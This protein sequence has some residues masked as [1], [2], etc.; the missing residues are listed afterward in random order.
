[1]KVLHVIPS[2]SPARGGPSFSVRAVTAGL[3]SLGATVHV[4]TTDD[5]GASRLPVPLEVA[6][7]EQG[8]TYWRFPR[9]IRF[10]TVSWPLARWLRAHCRD[11]DV[12]HI[13]AVF[14]YAC[15][16]AAWTAREAGLPYIVTPRGILNR[17]GIHTRRP[18]LKRLSYHLI[19][20]RFL[21]HATF[22]QY[23]CLQERTEA[24]ELGFRAPAIIIPNPVHPLPVFPEEL[25][26]RRRFTQLQDKLIYLFL[27]RIDRKKGLDFLL[28]AFAELYRNVPKAALVIA[29]AGDTG[30]ELSL[31]QLAASLGIQDDVVWTGF[32]DGPAKAAALADADVFVLPSYS[33]NFGVAVA[34]AMAAGVPVVVSDQVGIQEWVHPA[35]AGIVIPP[36]TAPL[37]QAMVTLA[38]DSALR[39]QMGQNGRAL[40]KE[41]FTVEAVSKQLLNL[42]Q[43]VLA[44]R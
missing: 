5:D 2:M 35:N 24:E 18:L 22:V 16:V 9:Q 43:D 41:N 33:E 37:T 40:V 4:A 17:W 34:E 32:L 21:T 7:Q 15:T 36:E 26:L 39:R 13:H 19:E 12:F 6:S 1:M 42:Y 20:K 44:R 8:V 28:P 29:G 3:A 31:R 11:Y 25:R 30:F 23:T 27:S 14:S 38:Q 10:Y